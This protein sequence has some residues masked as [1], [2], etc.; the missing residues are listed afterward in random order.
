M[1]V[2]EALVAHFNLSEE[3]R[4]MKYENT[5][6]SIFLTRLRSVRYSLKKEKYIDEVNKLTYQITKEG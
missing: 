4:V 2:S 3:Q 1:D 5:K 6:D